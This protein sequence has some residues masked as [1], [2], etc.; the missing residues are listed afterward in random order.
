MREYATPIDED[1]YALSEMLQFLWRGN[2]RTTDG[3]LKVY[4]AS[5]RMKGIFEDWLETI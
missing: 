1:K 3:K 2:I 5:K 4:I